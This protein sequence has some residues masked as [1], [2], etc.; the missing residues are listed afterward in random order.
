M[1]GMHRRPVILLV[2]ALLLALSLLQCTNSRKGKELNASVPP[3]INLSDALLQF[4]PAI[5]AF[6]QMERDSPSTKGGIVFTGSSSIRLWESLQEDMA[7]MEVV[8]RGFGGS[9]IRQVSYYA[10]RILLPLEPKLIVI[11]CGENDICN[12]VHGHEEPLQNFKDFVAIIHHSLPRTRILYLNMKP[13]PLRWEYWPKYQK[14]NRLIETYTRDQPL[15][16][17]V[18]ISPTMMAEDGKT[19][20]EIWKSDSLHM[21]EIGYEGWTKTVKP[22]VARIWKEISESVAP[23]ERRPRSNPRK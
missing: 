6:E 1:S 2:P 7:P 16:D 17:Y 22:E 13:S 20:P 19:K 8:N 14:G 3:K 15:L 10:P 11:Y 5:A 21:N 9:I 4:E 12:E 23:V 18:D